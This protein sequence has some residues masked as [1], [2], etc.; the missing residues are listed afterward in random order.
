MSYSFYKFFHIFSIFLTLT[1]FAIS[2]YCE[3]NKVRSIV[4]G[5]A[6]LFILV[7]GMGLLARIGVQ[8][9]GAF[10]FWVLAKMVIW[11]LVA[12]LIPIW[13]K[14]LTSLKNFGYGLLIV[15]ASLAAYLAINKPFTIG[16]IF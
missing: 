12:I 8:H 9:G 16:D 3:K 4:S 2:F 11:G 13:I 6:S 1:L 14:R 5:V 10:P 15:L 7:S